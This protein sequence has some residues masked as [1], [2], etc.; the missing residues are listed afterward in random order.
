MTF[1]AVYQLSQAVLLNRYSPP[2]GLSPVYAREGTMAQ[3]GL[4]GYPALIFSPGA[5]ALFPPNTASHRSVRKPAIE[6]KT[7]LWDLQVVQW[8]RI[9]L[10]M[11]ET[12]VRF[13][14]CEVPTC[15]GQLQPVCHNYWACV[16]ESVF[17]DKRSHLSEKPGYCQQWETQVMQPGEVCVQQ[18]RTSTT[19]NKLI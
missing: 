14:I 17:C 7:L 13:L 8:L 16:L 4:E 10:P 11:Q 12:R 18:W 6:D 3:R 15:G 9:R 19:K 1:G 2:P 5:L